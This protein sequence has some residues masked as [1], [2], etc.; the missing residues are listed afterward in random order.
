[1]TT[2]L[3]RKWKCDVTL[4]LTLATGFVPLK[5][6]TDFDPEIAPNLEDASDYDTNGWTSS[7]PTMQ[8][9][10]AQAT[11]FRQQI[12]GTYDPGQELIRSAIGVFQAA[13]RIGVR[14]YDRNGGPEAFSGVA[15]PTWKRSNT[16]YKNLEQAVVTF[17][18]TDVALNQGITNP[19]NA[20]TTPVITGVSP[21]SPAPGSAKSIAIIGSGFTGVTA[22]SIG[23]VA[24]TSFAFI[25]DQLITAVLPTAAA[26][27]APV[28][29]T[30]TTASTAFP[31]TRAA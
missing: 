20:P 22:V 23:G 10:T 9:W 14:W 16:A 25:N 30:T 19:W 29:V 12:G 3:A 17:T 27:S 4:D 8:S 2:T 11:F 24:A 7:E 28:I 6:I 5:R 26:G 18:G 1:M 21:T 31:L 15:I 13:A